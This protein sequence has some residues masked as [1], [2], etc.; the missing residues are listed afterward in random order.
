MAFCSKFMKSVRKV[1]DQVD[2][3]LGKTITEITKYTKL[4]KDL[5]LSPE[6]QA[7]LSIV[8]KGGKVNGWIEAA[9]GE[10]TD[11]TDTTKSLADKLKEWLDS[12][13]TEY[14]LNMKLQKLAAVAAKIA[15]TEAG[16]EPKKEHVYDGAVY[17]RII[18]EKD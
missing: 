11:V 17:A 1:M 12:S 16:N 7:L 14:D 6:V 9:L 13:A 10:I 15:D 18:A 4:I 2:S 5:G 3:V 8:D